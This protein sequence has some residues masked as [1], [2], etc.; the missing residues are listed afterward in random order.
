MNGFKQVVSATSNFDDLAVK[1]DWHFTE[2]IEE[3]FEKIRCGIEA[4]GK[5]V[6]DSEF[7]GQFNELSWIVNHLLSGWD[8]CYDVGE[9]LDDKIQ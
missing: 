9:G 5:V 3:Y 1:V 2:S 6:G 7:K 4:F 8:R